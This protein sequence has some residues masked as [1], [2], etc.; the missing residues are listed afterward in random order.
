MSDKNISIA[1]LTILIIQLFVLFSL[2][3]KFYRMENK[4]NE[5]FAPIE[6]VP[7]PEWEETKNGN[8]R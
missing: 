3:V 2:E 1:V 4:I 5:Y 7:L 8:V 6:D